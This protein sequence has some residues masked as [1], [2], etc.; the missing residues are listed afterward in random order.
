MARITDRPGRRRPASPMDSAF[1]RGTSSS[2]FRPFLYG[3][4]GLVALTVVM[5]KV[6]GVDRGVMAVIGG[7]IGVVGFVVYAVRTTGA[8]RREA[9]EKRHQFYDQFTVDEERAPKH[10]E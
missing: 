6:F 2:F 10:G 3:G 7:A 8:A 9:D 5:S 4:F 1:L